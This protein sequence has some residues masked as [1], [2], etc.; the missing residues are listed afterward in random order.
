MYAGRQRKAGRADLR[1]ELICFI[2]QSGEAACNFPSKGSVVPA[3]A[4]YSINNPFGRVNTK[5]LSVAQ[6]LFFILLLVYSASLPV[7]M[8]CSFYFG[9][10]PE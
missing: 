7:A 9:K 1:C 2:E 4:D 3:A 8:L 6:H 10:L 5:Y